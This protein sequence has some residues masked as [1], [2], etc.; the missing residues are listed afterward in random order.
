MESTE[1]W[2]PEV[3]E[4]PYKKCS[5]FWFLFT[6][7]LCFELR[8]C[9]PLLIWVQC[10]WKQNNIISSGWF[11]NTA[12]GGHLCD[13]LCQLYLPPKRSCLPWWQSVEVSYLFIQFVISCHFV[14]F[15]ARISYV[16]NNYY[17]SFF[18]FGI[19]YLLYI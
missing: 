7:I 2:S 17:I 8:Q 5:P 18:L 4:F 11:P 12:L 1:Q 3:R 15:R 16:F 9:F 13:K 14:F 10:Y 19:I 6:Q